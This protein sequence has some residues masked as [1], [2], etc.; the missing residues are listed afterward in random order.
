MTINE[1]FYIIYGSYNC[2]HCKT[3]FNICANLENK[4]HM[5][6]TFLE[7]ET[8]S[9]KK[10]LKKVLKLS[11]NTIPAVVEIKDGKAQFIGGQNEFIDDI[12]IFML[13]NGS[14]TPKKK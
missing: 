3:I 4:L 1:K 12:M 13:Q 14:F 5:Q 6:F 11:E 2:P 10:E 7:I 8:H 9:N